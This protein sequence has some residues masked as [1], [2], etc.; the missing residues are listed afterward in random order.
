M[1]L[2]DHVCFCRHST[3]LCFEQIAKEYAGGD[4]QAPWQK[5]RR[6][7]HGLRLRFLAGFGYRGSDLASFGLRV[8]VLAGFGL[9]GVRFG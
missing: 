4:A 1:D 5:R 2:W 7:K 3:N 8:S 6:G 9:L